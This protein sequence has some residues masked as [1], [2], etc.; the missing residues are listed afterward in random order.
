MQGDGNLVL[1]N[2]MF[3]P[4]WATNTP[5]N[6]GAQLNI[7]DDG[8]LVLVSA[9][10]QVLWALSRAH[11]PTSC[12]LL[13][14]GQGLNQGQTLPSCDNRSV[15]A[16]QGDGNVVLDFLGTAL[17]ASGTNGQSGPLVALQMQGDGNLVLVDYTN[18]VARWSSN[19]WG[20]PG[21]YT[22]VQDDGNLVVYSASN[23][24]LWAS[25]TCCH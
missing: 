22:R 6:P 18:N 12:G 15:L 11:P 1:S 16:M 14:A 23:A 2:A 3:A 4:I 24:P 13:T 5:G 7:Q 10:G 21:A 17:W 25:N 20:N 19:T 9:S 8:N